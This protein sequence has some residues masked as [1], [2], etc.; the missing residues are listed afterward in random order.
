MMKDFGFQRPY[1]DYKDM[2]SKEDFDGVMVVTPHHLLKDAVIAAIEAGNNVFVEKPMATTMAE[3]IEIRE[4][5]KKAGV[6]VMVGFCVRY[7]DGRMLMKSLL[8][9]GVVGEV[10]HVNAA[11]AGPPHALN[12]W[13]ADPRRGGGQ[14]FWLGSH[15]T[16]QVLWMVGSEVERVYGEIFWHPKT[17]ADQNSAYTMRFKNGV[18]A[19]VICSQNVG[20][21]ADFLEVMG[22]AGRIR[23]DWPSNVVEVYSETM[24]DFNDPVTIRPKRLTNFEMYQAELT[25]WAESLAQKTAPPMTVDDGINMLQVLDAVFESGRTGKPV[26]LS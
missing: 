7:A 11:K 22:S 16:D 26:T 8:D 24:R 23:A 2:L 3:G 5:A 9:K 15:I 20:G 12:T 14:L 4:A 10:V 25:R 6:E 13:Q 18:I 21:G 19:N 1:L 17:G